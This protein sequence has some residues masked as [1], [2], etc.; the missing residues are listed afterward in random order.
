MADLFSGHGGV[1]RTV[2][3]LGF[4]ARQWEIELGPQGDLTSRKVRAHIKRDIRR[5]KVLSAMV[6]PPCTTFSV[7]RDRTAVI[8]TRRRPWGLS[9]VSA[10]D[11]AKLLEGNR[12]MRAAID[13][14]KYLHRYGI[15]WILEHPFSSKAWFLPELQSLEQTPNVQVAVCDFCQYNAQWRKRTRFLCGHVDG[16]DLARLQKRCWGHGIC[17]R[18]NKPHIQLTGSNSQ[19]VPW[20][21][22]AQP[23]PGQLC[24]HLAYVLSAKYLT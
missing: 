20:T 23:Y 9:Q 7:A 17:S 2:L 21:R 18:T 22:I 13:L 14:I 15:P 24:H 8:R 1:S 3:R 5:G 12:C 10:K 4:A 11:R 16:Q 6:A 19:G